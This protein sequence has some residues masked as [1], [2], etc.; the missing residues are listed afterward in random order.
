MRRISKWGRVMLV[1]G[2]WGR[3]F[4]RNIIKKY[5]KKLFLHRIVIVFNDD[6]DVDDV[7][8]G[9][10]DDGNVFHL[11]TIMHLKISIY[12]SGLMVATNRESRSYH[13]RI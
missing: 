8:N 4:F 1:A 13:C 7:D 9:G 2:E 3:E 5:F 12:T 6:E 10:D 11:C